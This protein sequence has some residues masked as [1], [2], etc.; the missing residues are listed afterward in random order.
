LLAVKQRSLGADVNETP[1]ARLLRHVQELTRPLNVRVPE[2]LACAP[3]LHVGRAV[4]DCFAASDRVRSDAAQL[5]AHGRGSCGADGRV[6]AFRS[7]Q[8]EQRVA[9]RERT[10]DRT[11]DEP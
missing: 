1:R 6:A 7:R 10:H 8:R 9:T 3:L 4:N 5:A 11:A 2:L